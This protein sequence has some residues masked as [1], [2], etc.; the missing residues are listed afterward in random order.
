MGLRS[1]QRSFESNLSPQLA[2]RH[3]PALAVYHHRAHL[4]GANAR[5]G[6]PGRYRQGFV[7]ILCVNQI[8]SEQCLSG[9][10][11]RTM[12]DDRLAVLD[13]H[14]RRGRGRLQGVARL[15]IATLDNR[16]GEFAVFFHHLGAISITRTVGFTLIDEE[17]VLHMVSLRD[18][19]LLSPSSRTGDCKIDGN[20][21]NIGIMHLTNQGTRTRL[22]SEIEAYHVFDPDRCFQA[23]R[24]PSPR[25]V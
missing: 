17:E 18:V 13:P 12:R 23:D 8:V 2:R 24:G 20:K 7:E 16:L 21:L 9:L 14:G 11:E 6:N 19:M 22:A 25:Y 10:G 4:D 5:R 3:Q 1:R 15:E